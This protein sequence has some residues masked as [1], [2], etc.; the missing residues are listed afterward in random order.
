MPDWIVH[1]HYLLWFVIPLII[2]TFAFDLDH[3]KC[4]PDMDRNGCRG[5]FHTLEFALVIIALVSAF[6]LHMY[7]DYVKY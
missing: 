1:G 5:I 3:L 2:F 7:L 6:L 4:Y